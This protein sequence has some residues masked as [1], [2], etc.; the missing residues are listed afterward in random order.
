ML[1][2]SRRAEEA[3]V[4][5]QSSVVIHVLGVQGKSV[6]IGVEAPP[7]VKVLRGELA[8]APAPQ[9]AP[10]RST[11]HAVRIRLD[12]VGVLT[13]KLQQQWEA[14]CNE[15]AEA[16]L[17]KLAEAVDFLDR[18]WAKNASGRPAQ[19]EAR[20][21]RRSL[22]VED[23]ADQ[24]EL[25]AGLLS[26][27]GCDCD[28]AEDGQAALDFL[29]SHERPDFVLLDMW[30]PRCNGP[31]TVKR[32]RR[33]PRLDGLKVFAVSATSPQDLGVPTGPQGVD[34]WFPKPLDPQTLWESIQKHLAAKSVSN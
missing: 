16:T 6:R 11:S 13:R 21:K 31:E 34:A 28:T 9:P 15:E 22:L 2:L 12:D 18:E 19:K 5:P 14:G 25:L 1:V 30:M 8:G 33:D 17:R 26:L 24:R 3:I 10:K 20:H 7:E 4:F 32:I 29:A 23:D 27:A